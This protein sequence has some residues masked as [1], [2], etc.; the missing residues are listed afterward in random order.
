MIVVMNNT[1]FNVIDVELRAFPPTE[2]IPPA[3]SWE[4]KGDDW[5]EALK[6]ASAGNRKSFQRV[7]TLF[8]RSLCKRRGRG[9]SA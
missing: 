5:L 3:F 2:L 7:H 1:A 9:M 4:V 8:S 6:S